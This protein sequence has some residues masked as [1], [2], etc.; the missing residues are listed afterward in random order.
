MVRF[1]PDP[2]PTPDA[3]LVV[4]LNRGDGE[5]F[6]E[7][8]ERYRDWVARLAYRL[9]G[10][11]DDTLDILQGTFAHLL[12]KAP[13]LQLHT[14]L[15][16][17]L[18]PVVKDLADSAGRR[19]GR[20]ISQDV[21]LGQAIVPSYT[22]I[23]SSTAELASVLAGLPQA[24]REVLLMRFVDGLSLEEIGDALD[25]PSGTV[26]SRLRSALAQLRDDPR[27]ESHF[28]PQ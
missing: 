1:E 4:A 11:Q 16:V 7:L 10:N 26:Q 5:A 8:Y 17:F 14:K 6:E 24:Q 18:Y 19:R 28:E 2:G 22:C 15:T 25:I 12:E 23:D 20:D 3:D 27:T 21:I 13:R 9:T